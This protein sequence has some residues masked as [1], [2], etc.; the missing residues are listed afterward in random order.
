MKRNVIVS[1]AIACVVIVI[2]CNK[3]KDLTNI[4]IDLPYSQTIAIPSASV[5][6]T[7][8]THYFPTSGVHYSSSLL[9]VASGQQSIISQYKTSANLITT[10]YMRSLTLIDSPATANFT[11]LDTAQ[12]YICK[13]TTDSTLIAYKYGVTNLDSL[14]MNVDTAVNLKSY[15][16]QDTFYFRFSGHFVSLPPNSL[17]Q[18]K[19]NTMMHLTAN[20][21]N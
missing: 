13:S 19:I 10:F 2:S 4:N 16:L 7:S 11:Y 20:P 12:V 1:L 21:L 18:I 8:L 3:L 9:P 5:Y 14:V 17:Q 6:D 15:F